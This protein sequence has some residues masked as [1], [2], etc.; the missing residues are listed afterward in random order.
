MLISSRRPFGEYVF[1]CTLPE[2][3]TRP[4]Q[5]TV[6]QYQTSLSSHYYVGV[7]FFFLPPSKGSTA[8][9]HNIWRRLVKVSIYPWF[10]Q[11]RRH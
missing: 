11:G 1:M 10:W 6:N 8:P 9:L 4:V 3:S 5:H 2:N 7:P